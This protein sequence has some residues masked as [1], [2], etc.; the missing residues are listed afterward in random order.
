M[1]ILIPGLSNGETRN[2]LF[3]SAISGRTADRFSF[4]D[5]TSPSRTSRVS[6]PTYTID[7]LG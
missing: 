1:Q 7:P 5:L 2:F 4:S 3:T 6:A